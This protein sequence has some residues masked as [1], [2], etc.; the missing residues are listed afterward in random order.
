MGVG[1]GNS[2]GEVGGD[3]RGVGRGGS[4][5]ELGGDG[6]GVGGDAAAVAGQ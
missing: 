2:K 3:G 6:R 5:R 1:G 4:Q